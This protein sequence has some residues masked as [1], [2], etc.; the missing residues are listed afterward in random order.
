MCAARNKMM[1]TATEDYYVSLD[2]DSWFIRGDEIAIAVDYLERH[3]EA[4]AVA[5]DI[6]APDSPQPVPRGVRHSVGMFIGCG[7]VLRLSTVKD[8]RR[9]RA[10]FREPTVARK[11]TF[12]SG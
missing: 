9:L 7:H 1:L 3:P 6:L 11:K 8:A 10:S 2:D 5:F 4:A 12:A